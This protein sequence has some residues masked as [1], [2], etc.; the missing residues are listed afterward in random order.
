MPT[1]CGDGV[2]DVWP[3]SWLEE[4]YLAHAAQPAPLRIDLREDGVGEFTAHIVALEDVSHAVVVMVAVEDDHVA[5]SGGGTSHLPYHARAFMTSVMGDA[6]EIAAGESTDIAK[7][8]AV[9]PSRDYA[10]MG[11]ACWVQKPGGVNPSPQPYGDIP[12][13]NQVLQAA[14]TPTMSTGVAELSETGLSLHPA[15]PNPFAQASAL[16]FE[17]SRPGHV[18]LEVFDV[19]GRRVAQLVDAEL[20]AGR[21]GARWDGL[22]SEG[23]RCAAGVYLSRLVD[24]DGR[25]AVRKLVKVR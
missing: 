13:K 2:S 16:S 6:F 5:A 8:F 17:I 19:S 12:I 24:A 21:H 7:S 18:L 4:D 10:N 25:Q 14:F 22:D 15:S 20:P 3:V 9:G 1:V 23:H 11:V